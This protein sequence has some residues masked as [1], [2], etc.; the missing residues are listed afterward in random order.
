MSG[1]RQRTVPPIIAGAIILALWYGARAVLGVKPFVLPVPHEIVIAAWQ[2]RSVLAQAGAFTFAAALFGFLAAGGIGFLI[3][4]VFAVSLPLRRALMP[5]VLALQMTPVIILAP[6]FMLWLGPGFPAVIA[7]TFMIC[8]FPVVANTT[9]GFMS[10]DRH[11]TELF[12]MCGS[13]RRDEILRLRVPSALP[14]FLTGLR[15]AGTLAPIG[16]I[17]GDYLVG[18]AQNS[19]G[20]LGFMTITYF[21]QLKTPELFAAG[22]TACVIGF[23]FVDGVHLLH[24]WALHAWH[25]SAR[26]QE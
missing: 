21:S 18:S 23:I 15:I 16:A 22:L 17:T 11:L 24:H 13:S 12:V 10:V 2:Q 14:Y 5:Y 9:M 1:F 6:I 8:F 4:L 7:V 3:A 25:E 19:I 26:R 20:G